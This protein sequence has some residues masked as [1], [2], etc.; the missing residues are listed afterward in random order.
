MKRLLAVGLAGLLIGAASLVALDEKELT[1]KMK[2][3]G[4]HM[5]G[6][7]KSMGAGAMPDVAAHAKAMVSALEGTDSFWADRKN[8]EAVKW[9]K[10]GHTAAMALAKAAE[11]GDAAAARTAS[12]AMGASCKSC[13]EKYREKLPD[14]TYRIKQ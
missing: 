4:E 8:D 14:G 2:A 11:A 1:K 12:S 10:D 7:R 5:N 9:S 6:L 3:A 13:H